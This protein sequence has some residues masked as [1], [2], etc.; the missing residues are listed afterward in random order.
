[1]GKGP[2]Y[3]GCM[4]PAKPSMDL[5]RSATDEHVLRAFLAE[6][7][8]TRAELAVRT[9]LSKPTASESVRRLTEA[10]LLRDTGQR[11]TGR[12]RVGSYYALS[13]TLGA[14]VVA[15]IAP[16]GIAVEVVDVRGV[17]VTR[18]VEPVDRPAGAR[19]VTERLRAAVEQAVAGSAVP[20]RLAVVSAA[21][22]VDRST[23]RLV[24]L[25]DAPFLLGEVLPV[26][27]LA[28]LV[29]GPV[30]VDNDVNWAARAER[31]AAAPRPLMNFGYLYLGEGL[32]CAVVSDGQVRRGHVGIAGEIA[33]VVTCGPRGRAMRFTDVFAALGLRQSGTTA[34]DTDAVLRMLDG[35]SARATGVR[36]ALARA[37]GG[38]LAA[39]VALTDPEL[40]VLGGS[41]GVHPAMLEAVREDF[42]AQ[43]RPVPVRAAAVLDEPSLRGARTAA[44]EELRATVLAPGLRSLAD[45]RS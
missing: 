42:G 21:D 29:D 30:L 44:L 9:G 45:A 13:D 23:G 11:T 14:A 32:G 3:T 35:S 18:V 7:R 19:E 20:T 4:P 8:L 43:P 10:G 41:W 25:P 12:G 38:V 6:A 1:L 37:I 31:D 34:I 24:H 16:E 22:P 27:V 26:E 17:V 36:T 28:P 2:N 15:G 5:V 40:V 39:A 33:H